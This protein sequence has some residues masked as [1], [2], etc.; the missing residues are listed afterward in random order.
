MCYH[1][2][3]QQIV[4]VSN[5]G[6][7]GVM[8]LRKGKLYAM[9][10]NFEEDL[11]SV[12]IMKDGKKVVASS[13]DGILNIFSWDYFGDCNDRIVGHPGT[14]DSIISYD[15]DTLITGCEDGLIRAVS[16]LP[17]KIVAIL[18]DPLDNE[19]EVFHI[20]KV[21]LSYDKMFVASCTLDDMVKIIDV[22][23]LKH[24]IKNDDFDE[25]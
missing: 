21:S 19:E 5:D 20:Q 4:S 18:G 12:V 22:S 17:N 9:S 6:M 8:D 13:S 25:D 1:K 14:I 24:R 10:D 15:D 2:E 23:N 3:S 7:L 11:L 16:V